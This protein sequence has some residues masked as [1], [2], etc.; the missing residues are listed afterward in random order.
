MDSIVKHKR[1]PQILLRLEVSLFNNR[2]PNT[3]WIWSR[4]LWRKYVSTYKKTNT[5]GYSKTSPPISHGMNWESSQLNLIKNLPKTSIIP[6]P[7][8]AS[9]KWTT[10]LNAVAWKRYRSRIAMKDQNQSLFKQAIMKSSL[11]SSFKVL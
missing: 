11:E 2:Y 9:S 8:S 1:R 10:T 5:D 7:N 3:W 6:S 4:I